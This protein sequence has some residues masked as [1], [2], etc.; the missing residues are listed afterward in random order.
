MILAIMSVLRKSVGLILMHAITACTLIGEEPTKRI[1]WENTNL[2]GSPD[3]PLPYTFEKT[4]TNVELNRPIYLVEEP[5]PSDFLLVILQGGEKNQPSRILRLKNDPETKKAK[6]FFELHKRLIYALTFDPD[7]INNRQVYLFH[8]GPNGQPKRSNK[9]SRFV[10]TDDPDP[11]CDPDSETV[12]IEWD[13]AGHD[14]GDLAF[15]PDGMLYLTTGDGSGDSDTRVTGQTLDDLNGAVLRIDVSKTSEENP[16]DIPPDNPFVN[17]P[18]ARPEIWAYGLRNPWRMDIDQRSGQI[19]VGNN[20]Q[21]LWETAHLVRPGENYGWSVY[22]GSYP[23]YP[24]RQLGPTPHVLPT[25]EHP[26]SEF[27]SLTGGVVYRGTRWEELDGAYVYGDYSTGQVW[28]ALHDGKKLVWHRKLADTN[29]MITAFR[30]VGDGDLL[31]AD[32]GGSLHRMKSVPKENLEQ[33]SEKMFPTLLSETGLFSPNDL[34]K[35]APGLIPYSV[36]APAWND[37][38]KVQRWMAIPGNARPTYKAES[39]WE[40][41]D[42]TA[43]VQTL[44]LEAEIGKPES[45]F[46]VETRVQLRQQGEWI[47]YSYRWNKNQTQAR[48]VTKEGESAVFSIRSNDGRKELRQQS[49][50]FPSRSECAICHNRAT[51]YVLGITGSQLQRN[52]NYGGGTGLKNQ[53]QQ[54]AEISV[55]GSQPKPPKPLTNPYSKDQD[56]NERARAYLHVNCSICHV[57]SGGGNAKM[58]LRLG[59]GKQRMNVFDARPQ[60][61]T[62]G[63]ADAML[64]APG[65]P[66]RSVLHRRISRRGQGQMPPLAS[67]QIDHAGAQL[68]ANWIAMMAPSKSTVNA[69]KIEDFTADLNDNFGAKDRSFLSGKQAFLNTGCIQCHR[70]AGEGGSVGPDLTGLTR[71]RSPHEILESILDPSAK[72]TDPKFTIPASVPPISVMPSGMVNVLEKDALLDLLYYLW[73]DGR[74]R[75]A[76][77]VTEYRHNSHADIIVSRLL[78]T[79]TLDGKGK[80]S[81]L[82]LASLYTDQI[83]ENDTSR[84][85]SEKHGFPIYP[86]IAGALQ[87]GTDGLAVD[88]VMLIA[89]HGKYPKSATG[90]TVYPKRR[91]WEEILAVFNKSDR[92]VPVFID[93]HVADNWEDAKFI[94]DSAKQMN[95]PLMA[96]SSLPTTWRRPVADV[97][98]DEKLDEIVAITFHTTDAYGFHALE[99][100]QALAEQRQDGETGIRS[101]QSVSGDEVWKAFD[102]G[103]TF[104]RKLFDAAWGRLT[105][106]RDKDGP[107]R[108]A[109]AEPRLFSIEHADGLRVH[110]I[111]LNG[112]AN[113][114]SAAWRYTKDQKIESSL[115]W[116]QEGRPGMHFTWLLNGI[117]KMVM[118]G[119]PSWPVERTLLTSG[120]LDAL[121]ISLKDKERLTETPHLMFPYNSSWRWNSPPPPPPIRPWSEQ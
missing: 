69:W 31:V 27:R 3:P 64:I 93:K 12:I 17:L 101:V 42:K 46:R 70:F 90:N 1:L 19:W 82:D 40:F 71:Q 95:I 32:N 109:V 79:D 36:N 98:R 10:V 116:T 85:L 13:S 106:K 44:S 55:L 117:E 113:E 52:H 62:F 111:E 60:H 35:P 43:L 83:P 94:Y 76:A 114:W 30:V 25:I 81:P 73:R 50:R 89:E 120:T 28:A 118:T 26:H 99:F 61:S 110:L 63:I 59:T 77:I 37:G 115:F 20:G 91:F 48:L 108:E 47:G 74:P 78:Q 97:A 38:A 23:F 24:N 54:L 57:E 92:H 18:G 75:V 66:A 65:D 39:G 112:A 41:P 105:N 86:T 56:I 96:G 6:P 14:G 103:E 8:H 100:I 104:D 45:S 67:N 80:K 88:G 51:N 58:E 72:I 33:I 9:I 87:L 121:L 49:W 119:K 5:D 84:Q 102:D 29:L 107:R 4:F 11:H 7:Y 34:S 22:E 16:Y 15:G 53:L 2:I 21:D 68:I